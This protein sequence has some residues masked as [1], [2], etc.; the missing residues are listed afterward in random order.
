MVFAV[1]TGLSFGS[2]LKSFMADPSKLDLIRQSGTDL[3]GEVWRV[4]PFAA[5]AQPPGLVTSYPPSEKGKTS[6]A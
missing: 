5:W 3:G 2:I 4:F 6:A 1:G